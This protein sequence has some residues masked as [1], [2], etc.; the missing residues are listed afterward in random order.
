MKYIAPEAELVL[1][2]TETIFWGSDDALPDD[3]D[4]DALATQELAWD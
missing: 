4:T 2:E 3:D 1:L